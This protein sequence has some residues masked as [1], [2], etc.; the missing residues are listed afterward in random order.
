MKKQ[1]KLLLI[2][3]ITILMWGSAIFPQF[4]NNLIPI[5]EAGTCG[6]QSCGGGTCPA[7]CPGIVDLVYGGCFK[8]DGAGELF[9][10]GTP[11]NPCADVVGNDTIPCPEIT[12]GTDCPPAC[13]PTEPICNPVL[14]GGSANCPSDQCDPTTADAGCNL[15]NAWSGVCYPN[16]VNTGCINGQS[17]TTTNIATGCYETLTP[18]N[19]CDEPWTP[20]AAP[21]PTAAPGEPTSP[22]VPTATP[23]PISLFQGTFYEDENATVTGLGG[24]DNLCT[25]DTSSAINVAVAAPGS[26]AN[27]SRGAESVNGTLIG[28]GYVAYVATNNSDYT[29]SLQLPNPPPDPD[30]AWECACNTDPSD[31]YRCLYTNQTPSDLVDVNFFLKRAIVAEAAWFQTMGGSSWAANTITSIIPS[32]TCT[33][34]SCSPAL[35]S[36]DPSGTENSA[37]FPLT[38][39]GSVITSSTGGTYIHETDARSTAAQAQATGVEVPTENYDY[40]YDKFGDEAETLSNASKPIVGTDLAIYQ[41]NGD[42]TIDEGNLWNLSS[43]EKII[44]FIDGNLVIDDSTASESRLVT[45]EEG[46]DAFLMFVISGDMSI[47]KD[48]GYADILTDPAQ[49][50]ITNA[51]GVFVVDGLLTIEGDDA[52]TDRKFIGAGTFVGWSG[53]SLERNFDDGTDPTLNDNAATETF[54]FR[55][56]LLVNAPKTVKSAQMTWREVEPNF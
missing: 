49:A 42:L 20:T 17:C 4:S 36:N 28:T 39:N 5:A 10:D 13:D 9:C 34:P 22:P 3:I 21:Q 35:I 23:T 53:V 32:D 31:P 48:V 47:T 26:I 27:A 18:V 1:I 6:G 54:I 2:G 7:G 19:C 52:A 40:F 45:V 56:D 15:G 37:G 25:G 38:Q 43:T 55:P 14:Y 33:P 44:V 41:F 46:G 12:D 50:D 16:G 29:V 24:T 51:E 8:T 11:D 30:N